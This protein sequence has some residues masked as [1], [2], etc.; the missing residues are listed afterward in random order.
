MLGLAG[1]IVKAG[2]HDRDFLA[3]C[4]SGAD[5][6]LRYLEGQAD[7]GRKDAAWAA[8]ICGLD[9]GRIAELARRLVD[10][11]SMLTVSWSL[12]R[13][14]HGEQPF[15]A[16]LGLASVVGQIGLPGGG[17]G[18][19]YASLGAWG[20]AQSEP[21]SCHFTADEADRQLHSGGADQRH[22]AQSWQA[23][24]L[25]RRD[26]HLSGYEAGL[27]GGRQSLSS[28][29][30]S[31]PPVGSLDEARNDHRAGPDV[32]GDSPAGRHRAAGNHVDRAQRSCRQQALR[33]HPGDEEGDRAARRI[34][35]RLR[36]IQRD[37]R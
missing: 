18:Y 27:L 30:G 37:R 5:R 32:H 7:G 28:S 31:Q 34:P 35:L 2:R 12:Q 13:A 33:L 36:D 10:T 16:A 11:R 1:E 14:H 23:V 8:G 6:L 26:P 29:P 17:V 4:T 21:L 19:G 22:A 3:R 20:T 9:A 24:Q 25:R 15:W